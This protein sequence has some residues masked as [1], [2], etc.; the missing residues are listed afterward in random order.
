MPQQPASPVDRT[1]P[2]GWWIAPSVIS[3]AIFW[4]AIIAAALGWVG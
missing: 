1:A 2:N 4:V 3:G